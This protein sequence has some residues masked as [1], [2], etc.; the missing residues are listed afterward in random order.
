MPPLLLYFTVKSGV[1]YGEDVIVQNTWNRCKSHKVI[2]V[3]EINSCGT[4]DRG[5]DLSITLTTWGYGVYLIIPNLRLSIRVNTCGDGGG[6]SGKTDIIS[7]PI[8]NGGMIN[9]KLYGPI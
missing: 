6:R 2:W 8:L 4:E 1:V 7:P 5:L 3:I 9:I